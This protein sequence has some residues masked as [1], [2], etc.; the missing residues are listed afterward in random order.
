MLQ[1]CLL[2]ESDCFVSFEACFFYPLFNVQYQYPYL[3]EKLYC[4]VYNGAVILSNYSIIQN[5]FIINVTLDTM[6]VVFW[7]VLGSTPI[8]S[9]YNPVYFKYYCKQRDMK[10]CCPIWFSAAILFLNHQWHQNR[11]KLSSSRGTVVAASN[12]WSAEVH[13]SLLKFHGATTD[14]SKR[15][16]SS[17]VSLILLHNLII[18]VSVGSLYST[19]L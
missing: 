2:V 16:P 18:S 4:S 9:V 10:Y 8:S 19:I 5:L 1:C 12:S 14:I 17:V 3:L 6:F 11:E 15:S 13:T 7:L